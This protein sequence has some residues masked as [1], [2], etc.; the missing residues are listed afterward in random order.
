MLDYAEPYQEKMFLIIV[1]AYF[2]WL[3]VNSMNTLTATIKK[4]WTH[5]QNMIWLL[6]MW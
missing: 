4:L 6:S 2:K 5:F 3:D 1:E